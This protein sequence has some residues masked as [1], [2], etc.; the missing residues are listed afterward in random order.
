MVFHQYLLRTQNIPKVI[1]KHNNIFLKNNNRFFQAI[2][3]KQLYFSSSKHNEE[4]I[5]RESMAFDVLIIGAGLA[6]LSASIK[7]EQLCNIH[8]IDLSICVLEKGSEIGSHIL[9][10]DLFETR[11]LKQLLD[12]EDYDNWINIMSNE[13]DSIPALV[14]QDYVIL[15]K[16]FD[17]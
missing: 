15:I 11:G 10:G 6:G 17:R 13:Y 14:T 1:Q 9:S 16:G 5:E 2:A 8:N 7:L 3:A 4:E 12:D